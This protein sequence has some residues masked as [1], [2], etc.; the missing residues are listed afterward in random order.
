MASYQ[1]GSLLF[2]VVWLNLWKFL[3]YVGRAFDKMFLH[4][5]ET[6]FNNFPG[7]KSISYHFAYVF[8]IIC[9]AEVKDEVAVVADSF[10][11][12]VESAVVMHRGYLVSGC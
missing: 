5:G 6:S 3:L 12:V 4:I 1:C 10:F 2:R 8:S 9:L 11:P 7:D